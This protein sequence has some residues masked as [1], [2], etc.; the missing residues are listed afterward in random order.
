M[1]LAR[2]FQATATLSA[3]VAV[4]ISALGA[5]GPLAPKTAE[6][7]SLLATASLFHLTHSLALL[8][9]GQWQERRPAANGVVG[10]LLIAGIALFVG[11]IDWHVFTG[12]KITG[13]WTPLG[14]SMLIAA[15]LTWS[16]QILRSEAPKT[17]G[18]SDSGI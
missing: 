11:T 18:S 3:A 17:D 15:W 8:Q 13:P 14:G 7:Q 4:I 1:P 2:I 10:W 12:Q 16:V 5:H 9:F 6:L